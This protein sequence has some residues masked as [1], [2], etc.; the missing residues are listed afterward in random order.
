M[1]DGMSDTQP[2]EIYNDDRKLAQIITKKATMAELF[3]VGIDG[4]DG[5]GKSCIACKLARYLDSYLIK[6]DH[7]RRDRYSAEYVQSI[8]NKLLRKNFDEYASNSRIIL[9]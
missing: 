3:V 2:F 1:D 5:A 7:L 8:D 9:I 6:L 4:L